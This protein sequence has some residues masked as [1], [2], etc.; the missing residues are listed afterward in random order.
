MLQDLEQMTV[1][2]MLHDLGKAKIP[3]ENS[4]ETEC[5]DQ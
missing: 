2:A 4:G 3:L 5:F 1:S